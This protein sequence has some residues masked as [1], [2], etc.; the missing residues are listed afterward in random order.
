MCDQS[1]LSASDWLPQ[2]IRLWQCVPLRMYPFALA[3]RRP[4]GQPGRTERRRGSPSPPSLGLCLPGASFTPSLFP[5]LAFTLSFT[6]SL[7]NSYN[8]TRIS[9]ILSF[10]ILHPVHHLF[11][12]DIHFSPVIADLGF[13]TAFFNRKPQRDQTNLLD[14]SSRATAPDRYRI[15]AC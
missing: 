4:S 9:Q 1:S 2:L 15:F 6:L 14:L 5:L 11:L 13:A 10:L 7:P 3:A 8:K 12:K